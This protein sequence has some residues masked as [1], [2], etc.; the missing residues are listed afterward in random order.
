[1]V[2]PSSGDAVSKSGSHPAD[3]VAVLTEFQDVFETPTGLPPHIVYDHA[4]TLEVGHNPP[5]SRPYRHSPQQKDEVERQVA[6]MLKAGIVKPSMIPYAS[7]VLLVKKKDGSWR[8]C[9]DY[10]KLN[11]IT[12]K[13]KFPLPI[14]DELLDEL[15]GSKFFSKQDL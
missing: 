10:H 14:V 4:I 13:N 2:D 15:A 8:F 5:N 9:V 6:D 1:M 12:M 7:P 3:L 11:A